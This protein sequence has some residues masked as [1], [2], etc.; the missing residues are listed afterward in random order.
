[1]EP[2]EALKLI[3]RYKEQLELEEVEGFYVRKHL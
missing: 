2:A 1:M 3:K